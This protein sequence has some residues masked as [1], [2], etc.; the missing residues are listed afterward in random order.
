MLRNIQ[1]IPNYTYL[2]IKMLSPKGTI[3]VGTTVRHAY[4]CEAECC[5]LAV[6][7]TSKQELSKMLRTT[8][9]QA[10]D[11]KRVGTTLK[12]SNDVK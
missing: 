9:E 6:G 5:D 2:K 8:D 4:E 11:T 7:A 10:P 12:Q 1:S 3:T